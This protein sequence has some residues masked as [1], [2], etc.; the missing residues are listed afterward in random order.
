MDVQR[1][2]NLG[3]RVAK[4]DRLYLQAD[5]AM[6]RWM[7]H[8]TQENLDQWLNDKKAYRAFVEEYKPELEESGLDVDGVFASI[9]RELELVLGQMKA[10][11]S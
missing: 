4:L 3:A 2:V 9:D 8:P 10:I 5:T 1:M 7:K 11:S 6:G